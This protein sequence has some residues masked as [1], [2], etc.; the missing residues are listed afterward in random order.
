MVPKHVERA[1]ANTMLASKMVVGYENRHGFTISIA[2]SRKRLGKAT[3]ET[4]KKMWN[5]YE[6]DCDGEISGDSDEEE[7]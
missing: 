5:Q 4:F 7:Y 6:K 2:K 1:V 3:Q